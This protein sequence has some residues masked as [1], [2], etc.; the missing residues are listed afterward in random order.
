MPFER[1]AQPLLLGL[2]ENPLSLSPIVKAAVAEEATRLNFYPIHDRGLEAKIAA[3]LGHGL[4]EQNITLGHG[5]SDVLKRVAEAYIQPGDEAV[6]PVPT[7]PVY[8]MNVGNRGGVPVLT[9]C[10][11][12]F[13]L[14]VDA[15]LDQVT[16]K[17][18]LMYITS[19]NNPSGTVLPQNEL[20][21]LVSRLPDHVLLIFDEV[22]WHFGA[23]PNRARAYHHLDRKN[24]MILHSFSKAFGLAGLRLGYGITHAETAADFLCTEPVMRYNRLLT[25][26]AEAALL[27]TAHVV[28][29][30]ELVQAQRTC[31][32]EGL[33]ALPGIRR[34]L[35]SEASFVPFQPEGSSG[36]IAQ[37]LEAR[38]VFVRELGAFHM[39]G[40]LRV[41][42]GLPAANECFLA[43][44]Q[45]VL[46]HRPVVE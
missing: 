14:D 30:V 43:A 41:S 1:P 31:L 37:E 39:P 5:G 35:R 33:A 24:V 15:L 25:A 38:N 36:W 46:E 7:F 10:N 2:N 4:T 8:A 18:R 9:E 27:D 32:Y 16:P 6:I 42:V 22:Y 40:W 23:Q 28:Q 45:D 3:Y 19:P 13:T 21:Y 44:L 34:V 17:T 26:A 12:D 11:N 29:A 20:D